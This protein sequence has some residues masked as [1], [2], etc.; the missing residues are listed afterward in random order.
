MTC[1][2]D[3]QTEQEALQGQAD[4][5]HREPHPGQTHLGAPLHTEL[6]GLFMDLPTPNL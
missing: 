3:E 1:G 5:A 2:E 4:K 6:R